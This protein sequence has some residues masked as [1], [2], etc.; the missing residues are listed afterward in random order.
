MNSRELLKACFDASVAACQA[1]TV[2]PTSFSDHKGKTGII[3]IGKAGAAM[4]AAAVPRLPDPP[5]FVFAATRHGHVPRTMP[6]GIEVVEAGHPHPDSDSLKA[7]ARALALASTLGAE[8]RLLALVSGGGSSVLMEPADGVTVFEKKEVLKALHHCG[9]PIR[10]INTVRAALSNVKGG[11]L[12][13]AANGAMIETYVISDVPG[14]DPA[15][16]ASGPTVN[17]QQT[18]AL[19]ILDTYSIKVSKTLRR[20]IEGRAP[21]PR[22]P[23]QTRVIATA[24]TALSAA[25]HCL[26]RAGYCVINDG[27]AVE[28]DAS[29]LGLDIAARAQKLLDRGR[30]IALL[31]G[32]ETTVSLPDHGSGHG[33]RNTTFLLSLVIQL[34]GRPGIH[35]IAA[36][37]DGIDGSKD[38][39]GAI[40]DPGTLDRMRS[41]GV[42]PATAL[43]AA[44]AYSAFAAS[45]DLLVTGPTL[46]NV[47]DLRI[48]LIDP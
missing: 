34:D 8:D 31:S 44:D 17:A 22:F 7:G 47:N 26:E 3:G 12:G 13:A 11:R 48:V 46:T 15:F 35:A 4:V 33:G 28:G 16:V 29:Q 19:I 32:G 25:R 27:G 14:D 38:N 18:D 23:N 42:D 24:D 39:A 2:L 1:E 21:P 10:D 37:T 40:C 5:V 30:R 36:D 9:A 6:G 41:N 45:G 43:A 20:T